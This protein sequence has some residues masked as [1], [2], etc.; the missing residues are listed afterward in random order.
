MQADGDALPWSDCGRYA[1]L[2]LE[3]SIAS[4]RNCTPASKITFCDRGIPDTLC[5]LRL[6]GADDV[7]GTVR[8]QAPP[9]IELLAS[10]LS[11]D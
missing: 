3:R 4:F 2:M 7:E 10:N 1:R 9:D 6:I 5:Y 11:D 8:I